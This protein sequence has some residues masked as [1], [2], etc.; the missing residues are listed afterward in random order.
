MTRSIYAARL[1][2]AC[3]W[4]SNQTSGSNSIMRSPGVV[5]SHFSLVAS[6]LRDG[7]GRMPSRQSR[8]VASTLKSLKGAATGRLTAEAAV[9]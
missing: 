1:L 2:A 4:A 7:L 9:R 5:V 6:C 8:L 3:G